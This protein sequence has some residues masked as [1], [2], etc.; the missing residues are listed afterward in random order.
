MNHLTE[1]PYGFREKEF[2]MK[3]RKDIGVQEKK[4]QAE[5][6]EVKMLIHPRVSI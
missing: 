5:I 1:L 4:E 2:I 6:P 3:Y